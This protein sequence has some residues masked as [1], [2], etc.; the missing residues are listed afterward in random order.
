M[1][2]GNKVSPK[3]LPV[4]AVLFDFG[5]VLAEEGFRRGFEAIAVQNRLDPTSLY[6]LALEV[7]F[8]SGYV[9]GHVSEED[10]WRIIR[11][12]TGIRGK[13]NEEYTE[14]ILK[15]C[16]FRPEMI[17]I[18]RILRSRGLI[19]AILSD[20]TDWLNRLDERDHFFIE[21]DYIFNSYHLGKN[22]RDPTLVSE[23]IHTLNVTPQ[24]ALFIDNDPGN[25]ERANLCGLQTILYRKYECF[26]V[27]LN[28]ILGNIIV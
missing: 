21:F 18:V 4:K 13:S 15:R 23:V 5:G 8:E 22:K 2:F 9:T 16:I 28:K 7:V 20:Q 17:A 10:F 3:I 6:Q 11:H 27:N 19:T 1:I 14:E 26:I 25:I 12:H 24:K